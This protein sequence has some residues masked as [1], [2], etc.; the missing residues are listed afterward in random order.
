MFAEPNVSARPPSLVKQQL[1]PPPP[2]ALSVFHV[3]ALAR[4][5]SMRYGAPPLAQAG[6]SSQSPA[7]GDPRAAASTPGHRGAGR[8][9][10]TMSEVVVCLASGS[11]RGRGRGRKLGRE[12]GVKVARV[13]A[14]AGVGYVLLCC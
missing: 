5:S 14:T 3:G 4:P 7:T 8:H 10:R 2:P 1:P 6:L 13:V 9:R 11:K 12:G